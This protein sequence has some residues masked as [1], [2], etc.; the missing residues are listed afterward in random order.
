MASCGLSLSA[1]RPD[2]SSA[3][4]LEVGKCD[5][6]QV[7]TQTFGPGRV[8]PHQGGHRQGQGEPAFCATEGS[9]QRR[10]GLPVLAGAIGREGGNEPRE[11]L[12]RND[13]QWFIMVIPSFPPEHQ[14]EYHSGRFTN[15]WT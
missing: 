10:G 8:P 9:L 1:L 14:Q 13:Q 12:K 11:S 15:R 4:S 3:H 6:R 7:E 5:Q 2:L